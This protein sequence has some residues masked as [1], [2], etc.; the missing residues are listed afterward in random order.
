MTFDCRNCGNSI[1][2][3]DALVEAEF[4]F[5]ELNA[6]YHVCAH[7]ESC[8]HLRFGKDMV[9]LIDIVGAPGPHWNVVEEIQLSGTSVRS[10]PRFLHVWLED[11]HYEIAARDQ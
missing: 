3:Q 8:M 10:D 7:C 2:I 6:I 1:D 9:K 4:S 11:Q 5:P